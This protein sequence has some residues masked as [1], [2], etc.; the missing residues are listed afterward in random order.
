MGSAELP[1][2]V[3]YVTNSKSFSNQAIDTGEY[4]PS[5]AKAGGRGISAFFSPSGVYCSMFPSDLPRTNCLPFG[6]QATEWVQ[7]ELIVLGRA[8]SGNTHTRSKRLSEFAQGFAIF[9]DVQDG[10]RGIAE[11]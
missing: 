3:L 5:A 4:P 6:D 10:Q 9:T 7:G 2:C 1:T 11:G 8:V